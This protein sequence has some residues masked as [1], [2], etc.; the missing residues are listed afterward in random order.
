MAVAD[1]WNHRIQVFHANGT[2]AYQFGSW[3]FPDKFGSPN[4]VDFGPGGIMAVADAPPHN[5]VRV[6]HANGTLDYQLGSNGTAPG[7]FG[8]IPGVAFGPSGTLAVADAGNDRIQVFHANGTFDYQFGSRGGSPDEGW[9][10]LDVAFGPGGIMGVAGKTQPSSSLTFFQQLF[11]RPNNTVQVFHANGTFDY[12]FGS[13]GS[14]PGEFSSDFAIAFGP[15]GTMAVADRHNHR[16][17]VFHANGTFDYEFG[18]RGDGP[19]NFWSPTSVAFGPN[20][21]MAV[22]DGVNN[23]IQVFY[24]PSWGD[25]VPFESDM[26]AGR[27]PPGEY[28]TPTG[29]WVPFEADMAAPPPPAPPD[30]N[31]GPPP[32]PPSVH[33]CSVRAS[34]SEVAMTGVAGGYSA[35]VS[36]AV[37]NAGSEPFSGVMVDFTP[38]YAGALSDAGPNTAILPAS[39]TEVGTTGANGVFTAVPADGRLEVAGGLEGGQVASLFFRVNIPADAA[40]TGTAFAQAATYAPACE[41]PP[42]EGHAHAYVSENATVAHSLVV[43]APPVDP[44]PPPVVVPPPP[45]VVVPPPPPVVVPPPPPV[46][47]VPLNGTGP[48]QVNVTAVGNAAILTID[49]AGLADSA[50][51]GTESSTVTFPPTETIV[52]ASFATVSFP[53]GV[54]ASHVPADGRLA[55]RVAAD[56]PADGQV[57]GA[58]AY[59]GSGRVALQRVV[60]VGSGAGPGRIVFDMPVRIFLEGQAGGRAFYIDGADGAI[61][62]IDAACA[63][64]NATRVHVHLDG[65]GE[66]QID[67]ADGGKVVYTYHL[68]RFGTA[69]PENAAAPL[70]TTYTC[71]VGIGKADLGVSMAPGEYSEPV[72][73]T[74]INQG[75]LPFERVGLDVSPWRAVSGSGGPLPDGNLLATEV[76]SVEGA[77]GALSD[78]AAVAHG[79][80][81]GAESYLWFRVL[82]GGGLQGGTLAQDV[83][84][85]AE[86]AGP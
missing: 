81:G 40:D 53:P 26:A 60:E 34:H 5:R 46:V 35:V 84:Y 30:G 71:A 16:I 20:E 15:N 69:L 29:V 38:W 86:C 73:Q 85:R 83:T 49:V 2:F 76:A 58:L 72:R 41:P 80:G 13:D 65:S 44:G 27:P 3:L 66:C 12:E 78:G 32:S 22:A 17:Q 37:V 68:T 50:L 28:A 25:L 18:S 7:A 47:V 10:T 11:F 48:S 23:R 64:D 9:T 63:A 57:Q 36:Y 4:S 74:V 51:D 24:P 75:S 61:T 56:V 54:T 19:G 33:T 42:G 1:T 39:L 14:D 82:A 59:E 55:L 21:T 79:L 62:P 45:P 8:R 70:P 31:G 67:S 6:Y 77:Y 43:A 52:A